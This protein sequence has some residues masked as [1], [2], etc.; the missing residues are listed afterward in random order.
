M[1]GRKRSLS[2][3]LV[4]DDEELVLRVLV[5]ILQ[6]GGYM[7]SGV[8]SV[9]AA[10]W[11]VSRNSYDMA[12]VDVKLAGE[13]GPALAAEL[14][15]QGILTCLLS[16]DPMEQDAAGWSADEFLAKPVHPDIL[17]AKADTLLG[18]GGNGAP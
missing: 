4:V 13:D 5:S 11:A 7:A 16:G 10:R 2:R 1:S 9:G 14:R 6:H 18:V 15:G 17:I 3:I 12:F 8:P